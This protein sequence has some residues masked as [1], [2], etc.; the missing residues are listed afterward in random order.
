MSPLAERAAGARQRRRSLTCDRAAL[1]S[2]RR[3]AP[4]WALSLA[5]APGDP[6]RAG[7]GHLARLAPSPA[8]TPAADRR[9]PARARPAARGAG[10]GAAEEPPS[11][12]D[13]TAR[14][15]ADRQAGRNSRPGDAAGGPAAARCPA[16]GRAPARPGP[17]AAAAEMVRR[18]DLNSL[19]A[20][21]LG[22]PDAGA[23]G[24]GGDDLGRLVGEMRR[25]GLD[26]VFVLDATGSMSPYIDQA[27][28]P[29]RQ[30][31][32]V[33]G[34]MVPGTCGMARWPTR[35][36][37]TITAPTPS[38]SSRSPP[39]ARSWKGSSTTSSPTA[40]G[41]SRSPSTRP[42]AVVADAEQMGW[43][44]GRRKVVILVGDSTIHSSGR[45]AAFA[46]AR[47]IATKVGGN[48]Q[49]H[50]RR[51]HRAPGCP[52]ERTCSRTWPRSPAR[53]TARHSC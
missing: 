3:Q 8:A 26:V 4:A 35:T 20:D 22:G 2:V 19:V 29:L 15:Q 43:A 27:R 50:R 16:S 14:R 6:R 44:A 24:G 31:M 51:R 40:A 12:R 25:K 23:A 47:T 21:S 33:V 49:R 17:D 28:D 11:R 45:R 41:T 10:G 48:D 39:I 46:F 42:L 7:H 30:V 52:A 5:R 32:S 53:D 9:R 36:T 37:A 18:V 38:R 13:V 1:A 34:G